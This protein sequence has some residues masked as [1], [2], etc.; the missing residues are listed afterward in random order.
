MELGAA[1]ARNIKDAASSFGP[2]VSV[3]VTP[4]E[5]W[6]ELEAGV[7]PFFGRHSTERDVDLLFKKPWTLSKKAEFM[8]GLGP[9]WG[10]TRQY[11]VTTHSFACEA[12][13]DFMYLICFLIRAAPVF[14]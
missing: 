12:V 3:E 7:T 11:G 14:M 2:D 1:T 13:L 8:V 6:L 10:H 4:I 5:N 9:A